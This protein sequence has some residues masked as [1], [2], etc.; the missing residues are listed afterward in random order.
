MSVLCSFFC[1]EAG[2]ATLRGRGF[3]NPLPNASIG[4]FANCCLFVGWGCK[5]KSFGRY[6][7]GEWFPAA[8][9]AGGGFKGCYP[10]EGVAKDRLR[11]VAWGRPPLLLIN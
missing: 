10:V 5:K 9:S 3:V 8:C 6:G 1:P 2:V 11:A 4:L 7:R